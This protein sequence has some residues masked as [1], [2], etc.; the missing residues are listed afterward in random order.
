V[1]TDEQEQR[2]NTGGGIGLDGKDH[3]N[4]VNIYSHALDFNFSYGIT[5]RLQVNLVIPFVHNERSQV[6][7]Q[8]QPVVDTSVAYM[9]KDLQM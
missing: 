7:K 2:Q 8:T 3:G 4:A 1:G 5:N 6:L 9:L